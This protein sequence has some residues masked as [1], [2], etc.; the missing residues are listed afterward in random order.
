METIY[1]SHLAL[2]S[3][4]AFRMEI[5]GGRTVALCQT[6]F[7]T[8]RSQVYNDIMNRAAMEMDRTDRR[9]KILPAEKPDG[10]TQATRRET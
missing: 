9:R 1:C 10:S 4:I 7:K 2:D 5:G 6:C 3:E 8:V